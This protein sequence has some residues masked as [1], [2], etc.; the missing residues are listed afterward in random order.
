MTK[1][2]KADVFFE[3]GGGDYDAQTVDGLDGPPSVLR[4]D[5]GET[6]HRW[7]AILGGVRRRGIKAD[8]E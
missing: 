1:R 6:A 2:I 8:S 4:R 3:L 5:S 7:A